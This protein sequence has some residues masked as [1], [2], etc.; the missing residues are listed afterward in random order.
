MSGEDRIVESALHSYRVWRAERIVSLCELSRTARIRTSE[1]D[2]S[3]LVE[4]S[5]V[6][7]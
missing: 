7:V 6:C 5:P 1:L 4:Q 2:S 3:M